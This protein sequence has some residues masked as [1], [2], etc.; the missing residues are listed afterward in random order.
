MHWPAPAGGGGTSWTPS[1]LANL[2]AW[3]DA[4][5]STTIY[6]ATTGGSLP[7]SGND[8]ARWEDKSGG[9]Y[10]VTQGTAADRPHYVTNTLNGK[11]VIECSAQW[12]TAATA[13]DWTFLHDATGSTIVA[14]WK[15]GNSIDPNAAYSIMGTNGLATINIGAG[16]FYDDRSAI[17]RDDRIVS[18]VSRGVNNQ[19]AVN[20]VSGDG[21]LTA[22]APALLSL[23]TDPSNQSAANRSVF[24]VN[25]GGAIANNAA[26]DAPTSANPTFPVQ[27]GAAGNS[28]FPLTG[29]FAEVV[30]CDALLSQSDREKLE[31]YLA[32]KWGLTGNLPVSHPYKSTAP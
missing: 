4:D 9:G 1:N 3:Y 26:S 23:V 17:A 19:P 18:F 11:P 12:L 20:N 10:H 30:I 2:R 32:H 16:W 6:D 25:G 21:V 27:L 14:V 5:D 22:N 15:V 7:S 28:A 29:Y 24:R 13:S 31:G 8:V